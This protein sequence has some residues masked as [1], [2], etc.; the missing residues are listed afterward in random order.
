MSMPYRHEY[1]VKGSVAEKTG[2]AL[3]WEQVRRR[4]SGIAVSEQL[5][6]LLQNGH[7]S[8]KDPALGRGQVRLLRWG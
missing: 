6:S 2:C 4:S 5:D 7:Q 8:A 1:V 3:T